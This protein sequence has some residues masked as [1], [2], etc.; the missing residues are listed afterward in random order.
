MKYKWPIT[1]SGKYE[2][3]KDNN[4]DND[5]D[6]DNDRDDDNDNFDYLK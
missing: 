1:D 2:S 5:N 6:R 3:A 4:D